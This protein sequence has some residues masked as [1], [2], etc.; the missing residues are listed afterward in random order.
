MTE[1][2]TMNVNEVQII[3]VKPRNG[4]IA[5]ASCV[6]NE[7]LYLGS[8]AI[9]T[10]LNAEGFRLVYPTKKIENT[11]IPI[12]HPVNKDTGEAIHKAI[13][14]KL[15]RLYHMTDREINT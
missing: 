8:I 3:P 5:F 13:V 4:L 14:E 7:S 15:E 1:K 11:N 2:V 12:F 10:K 6:I 9:Y